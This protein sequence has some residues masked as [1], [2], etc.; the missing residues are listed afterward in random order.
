[1]SI[2]Y[3]QYHPKWTLIRR[4]ILNRSSY[5]CE[6]CGANQREEHPITG[7][8]VYLTIAHLDRNRNNNQFW[9]LAALCQRCHLIYDLNQRLYSLKY[10]SETQYCNGRLFNI[11]VQRNRSFRQF[12]LARSFIKRTF[13]NLE[14]VIITF[15]FTPHKNFQNEQGRNQA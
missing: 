6:C 1:M 12:I 10:G 14:P 8:I 9:N 13:Q 4:L 7:S 2:N 15:D 5:R 11:P 3:N